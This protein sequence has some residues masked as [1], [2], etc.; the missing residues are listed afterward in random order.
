MKKLIFAG[1]VL[2]LGTVNVFADCSSDP[3][4]SASVL[5]GRSVDADGG[6]E[7]WKESHCG[8]GNSG[9]LWKKGAGTAVDPAAEIGTWSISG[10]DVTYD[11]GSGGRYTWT[12]HNDGGSTYFFCNG[13]S[14]VASGTL[15]SLGDCSAPAPAP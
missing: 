10:N 2:A 4:V 3:A 12:L 11:Y 1:M 7:N 8:S 13:T 9:E 15:G 6:G 5:V 14:Q